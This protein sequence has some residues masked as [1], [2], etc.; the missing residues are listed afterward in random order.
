MSALALFQ[1]HLAGNKDFGKIHGALEFQVAAIGNARRVV[2]LKHCMAGIDVNAIDDEVRDRD[3]TACR[4]RH[5]RRRPTVPRC[6][7]AL[8]RKPNNSFS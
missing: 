6:N 7:P 4:R 3:K 8:L 2:V 1:F 5:H